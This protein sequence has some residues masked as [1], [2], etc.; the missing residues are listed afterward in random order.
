MKISRLNYGKSMLSSN[1]LLFLYISISLQYLVPSLF[2]LEPRT[3]N[4]IWTLDHMH[5]GVRWQPFGFPNC[6]EYDANRPVL[7]EHS[8]Y[9]QF[10]VSWNAAEPNPK[11]T[12]YSTHMSGYL[13]AIDHAVNLCL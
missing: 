11:N 2:S 8:S 9:A 12:D 4:Y 6:E 5:V 3:S 10:W 13:K 7:K 1:S